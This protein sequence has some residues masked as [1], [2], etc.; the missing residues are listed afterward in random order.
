MAK[1]VGPISLRDGSLRIDALLAWA[2]SQRDQLPPASFEIVPIEIPVAREPG[3]RFHLCSF[4][5]PRFD[6]HEARWV[7]RKF[8][9]A[10]AQAMGDAKLRRISISAGPQ[11]S[12]RLPSEVAWAENDE[13]EWFA[14]G[15][16][17]AIVE[18]LALVTHLGHKRSVGRGKVDRWSVDACE[19]WGDGF[20][21]VRDGKALRALPADWPGLIDPELQYATLTYPF[22]DH[23]MEHLCAVPDK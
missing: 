11:K 8:P 17:A 16:R 1:L 9:L 21:V 18:L 20:P 13:L 15:D 5:V 3:G 23:R 7:N 10:E 19:S 2:V 6:Q 14:I 12:Y 4:A 22:W